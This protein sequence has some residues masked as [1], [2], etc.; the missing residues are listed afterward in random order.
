M[1]TRKRQQTKTLVIDAGN[2]NTKVSLCGET[3]VIPSLLSANDGAYIRGGFRLASEDWIMGWDN[4][5]RPDKQ[6]IADK[7][8][9]K[10]ECLHLM[11]AGSL[12]AMSH[13]L[14][15]GDKVNVHLLTLNPD[16]RDYLN[17]A[18]SRGTSEL[19]IDGT[20]MQLQA[21]LA[22]VYPEGFGASLYAA[23][24]FH[25]SKRVAVLDIGNGT[26][27]LATYFVANKGLPRRES[28][29]AIGAGVQ[30]LLRLTTDLLTSEMT[31]GQVDEGLVRQ[32]MEDNTYRYLVSYE[33]IHIWETCVKA[34][35]T[36][37]EQAKV[38]QL[39]IQ[40]RKLLS[41]G[42]PVVLVGGGANISCIR[43]QLL[44][45]LSHQELTKV[46]DEAT[47]VGVRRLA[48]ELN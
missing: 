23:E 41:S 22:N 39:L 15:P 9:G 12:S 27:N 24:V 29:A 31:N 32:C 20:P 48:A 6:A 2:G 26:L 30:N 10:L 46:A 7:A 8:Q 40:T 45:V 42:V 37:L 25:G 11:L 36:W 5:S 38:K 28:F 13:L 1:A 47:T 4:V 16:K 33:G 3:E 19:E 43:E 34:A 21:E 44:E 14:Q 18:V 17:A 35:R